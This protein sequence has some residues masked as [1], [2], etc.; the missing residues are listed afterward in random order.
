MPMFATRTGNAFLI[1]SPEGAFL[2]QQWTTDFLEGVHRQRKSVAL[3][4]VVSAGQS[5]RF[6]RT[7]PKSKILPYLE[8]RL[9]SMDERQPEDWLSL[10]RD[11]D[12]FVRTLYMSDHA[13]LPTAGY[14]DRE[15]VKHWDI[16]RKQMNRDVGLRAVGVRV[17]LQPAQRDWRVEF[18]KHFRPGK[19]SGGGIAGWLRA[20]DT[21]KGSPDADPKLVAAKASGRAFCTQIQVILIYNAGPAE[22]RDAK[23]VLN[24][25][26]K[27]VVD[28]LGGNNIWKETRTKDVSG[29]KVSERSGRRT[30]AEPRELMTP[31]AP[32][33]S[34]RFV[35]SPRETAAL[36]P[37]HQSVPSPA[38]VEALLT[39]P[40]APKPEPV[41]PGVDTSPAQA[42][43]ATG[44]PVKGDAVRTESIP[45]LNT[46][47]EKLV[48]PNPTPV[49]S[50]DEERTRLHSAQPPE[51]P[52][53]RIP[54]RKDLSRGKSRADLDAVRRSAVAMAAR[55]SAARDHALS[56]R[57]L[58]IFSQL[59][60]LPLGS[61]QDIACAYGWSPTTCYQSS[62]TLKQAGLVASVELSAGGAREE[63]FWIPD[64]QWA[65]IMDDRPSPHADAMVQ[66]L[67]LNP[68]LVAAVYR[69]AGMA[70]QAVPDRKLLF[71]RWLRSHPFEAV[72]QFSD[73][74]AV[75]LWCGIWE[76]RE[77][78]EARLRKC[79][80]EL[81]R[82]HWS[83][84]LGTHRP[85]GI[86]FVVPHGWQAERVWRTVAGTA[87]EGV[88]AVYDLDGDTLSGD[89]D[90]RSSRGRV[91]SH[92]H[93]TPSP[94][95]ADV[96]RWIDLLVNDTSG[97][98]ARLLF[99][100]E[101]Q[102]GST[103]R[104]LQQLTRINGTNVRAGLDELMRRELIYQ[105]PDGGYVCEPWSLAMAA[106]RDRVWLGLPGRRCGPNKLA[107]HSGQ[108]RK[109]RADVL[110]LLGKCASAGCS[111]APGWQAVDGRFKP[112]GA[113]LIDQG[114]Y[115]PGWHYV[116][117]A[118]Q[119]KQESS[120]ARVLKHAWSETRTDRYPI[121]VIC[122]PEMED[123][124]WRL[125]AGRP[126]LTA[127]VSHI[128]SGPVVGRNGTA[129][130]RY[131]E[132][133]PVLAGPKAINAEEEIDAG[134]NHRA[135]CQRALL[136]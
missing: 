125:G 1:A 41:A 90:L 11:E 71:L 37:V 75:F 21:K 56:E 38:L 34:K 91:P 115:G 93:D 61:A 82:R 105:M 107:S 76:D 92:I 77:H 57:D 80:E 101:Q 58:T 84:D 103:P 7:A 16:I 46:E 113:V 124:C 20:S 106:R 47:Q 111:V 25:V 96:A 121:L 36:W 72:A 100:V 50:S 22:K 126:M 26:T 43:A 127:S 52:V 62:A 5:G 89:L 49:Q 40:A 24:R 70:A 109:R 44:A 63:R 55:T 48:W 108:Y 133:V 33:R 8:N 69:L 74:W 54:Y 83:G 51:Q 4:T 19:P 99:A 104:F 95:R 122:S 130:S 73:G 29:R 128:R 117:H 45:A 59:G 17:L 64:D 66:W 18:E 30:T 28:L 94:P 35:A 134:T 88:Y 98:M 118:G 116:V 42:S 114:P 15:V 102:P 79:S 53:T 14:S 123:V 12:A 2:D 10:R 136:K 119:A 78:L 67:W 112:V 87:W 6:I 131:G 97:H 135:V 110:R 81:D 23:A 3:E 39:P 31:V 85:G 68:Q 9:G 120:I 27:C 86:V 60:D 32:T 129:W 65:R 13:L 132:P